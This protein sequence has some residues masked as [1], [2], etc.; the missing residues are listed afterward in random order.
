MIFN[1][2]C[3]TV[4][5]TP[6]VRLNKLSEQTGSEIL[7]KLE[8]FN[9]G[10]SIKD[11]VAINMIKAAE[12]EGALK[13]GQCIIEPTSGNTGIGLA[14]AGAA[15]GYK[16][17]L[18]MPETMSIERRKLIAAYGA[19]IILTDGYEGMKGSIEMAEKLSQEK[20]YFMPQQFQNPH[21]SEA[22]ELTTAI[23][24][25]EDTE[26]KIDVFVSSAGTGGTV[27]GTG[28]VLKEKIP[29]VRIVAVEPSTSAVLSGG[30]PGPHGI[31]GIGPGFVPA[32]FDRRTVDEIIAV[33]TSDS[34]EMARRLAREE[35]MLLG[36]SSGC[37]VQ[38]ALK[39]A[40]ASKTPLRIVVIAPDG[41]ERYLST[42]LFDLKE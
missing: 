10:G 5:K 29:G 23:E 21:N 24:L 42:E 9:P 3:D 34:M 37:A 40:K 36:I 1:S 38:A 30:E 11:R 26:G 39:I 41:G 28:R 19:E 20:G 15:M 32:I 7:L 27:S 8:Y 6:L 31:Q 2:I 13:E 25:I 35:G 17:I 33:K 4:G 18:V 12:K 14:M 22:H 16:V